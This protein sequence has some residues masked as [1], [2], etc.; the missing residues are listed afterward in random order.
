MTFIAKVSKIWSLYY[1]IWELTNVASKGTK[2]V[3]YAGSP[4]QGCSTKHFQTFMGVLVAL[5]AKFSLFQ[6]LHLVGAF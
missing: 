6:N 3:A 1:I 5:G 2:R 4:M